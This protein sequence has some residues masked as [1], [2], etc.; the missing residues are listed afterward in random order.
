MVENRKRNKLSGLELGEGE[1][2]EKHKIMSI[3]P[4]N[5]HK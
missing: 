1:A 2:R 3:V 5:A 4:K